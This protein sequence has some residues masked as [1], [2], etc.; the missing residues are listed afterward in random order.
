MPRQ[1]FY[2]FWNDLPA[3]TRVHR[4]AMRAYHTNRELD[5]CYLNLRARGALRRAERGVWLKVGEVSAYAPVRGPHRE[6][7]AARIR[8]R[9]LH[10]SHGTLFH[11]KELLL[12][13]GVKSA[14]LYQELTKLE[15]SRDV[16]RIGRGKWVRT[17][18]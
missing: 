6:G 17:A 8:G 9:V 5:A 14:D 18:Q 3:G 4:K 13:L 2:N 12:Q 15:A 7:K 11:N 10:M 1:N 16:V